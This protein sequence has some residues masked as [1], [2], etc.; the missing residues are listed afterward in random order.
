MLRRRLSFHSRLLFLYYGLYYGISKRRV[1]TGNFSLLLS[2]LRLPSPANGGSE[3]AGLSSPACEIPIK[4][5]GIK[6]G[7]DTSRLERGNPSG[8]L[9]FLYLLT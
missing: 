7:K 6:A 5:A 9:T 3:D 1:R 8:R 2:R 4:V